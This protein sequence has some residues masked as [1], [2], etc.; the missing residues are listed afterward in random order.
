MILDIVLVLAGAALLAAAVRRRR[1]RGG[2]GWAKEPF[3]RQSWLFSMPGIALFLLGG[4]ALRM[5]DAA[6]L[7]PLRVVAFVVMAVGVVIFL[8]GALFLPV[9][10]RALPAW[11][12]P[13]VER[14]RREARERRADRRRRRAEKT[15]AGT[16]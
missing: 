13:V 2:R 3:A 11:V 9:P 14:E 1:G 7:G 4:G 15:T 6:D 16:R 5:A 12:R 10:A 8:W